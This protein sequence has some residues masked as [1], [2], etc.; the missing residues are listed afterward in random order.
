VAQPVEG[1][2]GRRRRAIGRA[3]RPAMAERAGGPQAARPKPG[4]VEGAVVGPAPRGCYRRCCR[5]RHSTLCHAA[6]ARMVLRGGRWNR[7]RPLSGSRGCPATCWERREA[8][9][10]AGVD[11]VGVGG[12]AVT[13]FL[14]ADGD[15]LGLRK[16]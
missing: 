12:G 10:Q 11:P 16:V 8:S 9:I 1:Q 3:F 15:A 6:G 2:A 13:R 14:G 4:A 5:R 7:R